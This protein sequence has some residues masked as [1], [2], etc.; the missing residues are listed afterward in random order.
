M[1]FEILLQRDHTSKMVCKHGKMERGTIG[2]LS[3]YDVNGDVIYNCYTME[4]S[5]MPTSECGQ[6]KPILA[7]TYSLHW[8]DSSVCVPYAY[9]QKG[10]NGRNRAI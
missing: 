5:G 4:N 3:I 2:Y 6:D 8:A 1:D 7:R 9:R 10:K